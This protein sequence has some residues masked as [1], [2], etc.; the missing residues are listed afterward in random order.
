MRRRGRAA[1]PREPVRGAQGAVR[2]ATCWSGP[3]RSTSRSSASPPSTG[4]RCG[5]GSTSPSTSSPATPLLKG[6]LEIYGPQFWRPY[7]HV[8][9]I[10]RAVVLVLESPRDRVAGRTFNVGANDENYQKGMIADEV[11]QA[12][13][14]QGRPRSSA[15]RTRATTGS[16]STASRRS[17]SSRGCA[18]PTASARSPRRSATASSPT[19][20]RRATGTPEA[21]ADDPP[22]RAGPP[23]TGARVRHRL[24]AQQRGSRRTA[25]T[26]S[27]SSSALAELRR[28]AARGG[29]QLRHLGAAR[30]A[31]P[32]GRRAGRRGHRA[33][34]H[35]HRPG[36]RG[37]LRRRLAG[38]RRLRRLLLPRRRRASPLPRRGVHAGGRRHRQPQ[39]RGAGSRPSSRCTCSARPPTWTPSPRARR[40]ARPRRR[41]RTRARRWARPTR[42]GCAARLAALAC[43]SFNGNKIVTS[44]GGGAILTDDDALA[45]GARYLT[46][47]AKEPGIEYIHHAVGYNYRM[48]NV[49]AALG[50]A[51]LE[52]HRRAP[53]RQA[54]ELRALR[55]APSGPSWR[56]RL[57]GPAG[58]E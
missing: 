28:R 18:W 7:C 32:V 25:S 48:N 54:R 19:P 10:A 39:R 36:Q 23:G 56:R 40:R 52:T 8:S 21:A 24:P 29:L 6:E 4:S 31:P 22:E 12:D 50:L 13:P 1:A 3:R 26:S 41:S 17:A 44:G 14:R 2:A 58:L 53:G 15:T 45:D 9:D 35:L 43:L 16:T 34:R 57:L 51:Q 38:V 49:L 11:A 33:R 30:L 42:A 27:A 5:H 20:T 47:Q 37:A 55:A 46:T